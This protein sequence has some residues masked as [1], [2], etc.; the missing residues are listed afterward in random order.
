MVVALVAALAGAIFAPGWAGDGAAR[1]SAARPQASPRKAYAL[2]PGSGWV[3][4]ELLVRFRDGVSRQVAREVHG[5]TGARLA[6]HIAGLGIDLVR[7]PTGVSIE[8]ALEVY[9]ADPRV[10]IVEPNLIRAPSDL[11]PND[12]DFGELWALLNTGQDHKLADSRFLRAAGT[13]DADIDATEAWDLETGD[14]AVVVGVIDTGVDVNHPDLAGSLWVNP[15]EVAGNGLDD[16]GNGYVDDVNGWNFADGN[17]DL[18]DEIGHGTHVAGII[19]AQLDNGIGTA[20]VCPGCRIMVLKFDLDL[21]SELEAL[22]YAAANGAVVV[23]GSYSGGQWSRL[24]RD[25]FRRAGQAGVLSV[26][27]AGNQSSDNDMAL[28]VDADGVGDSPAF[29]ASYD[30]SSIVSVAASNHRDENGYS[31]ACDM[32][33][34]PRYPCA[35]TNW[36]HDSV[37]LSAPGVDILST[38]PGGFGVFSGTSMAAP[39][40]AGVAG[41]VKSLHPSYTPE[42]VK[43]AMLGSVDHP[44]SLGVLEAFPGGPDNGQFTRTGGRLNAHQAL[45]V[46]AGAGPPQGDGNVQ[47]AKTIKMAAGGYVRWPQDVNDVYRKV[48]TRGRTYRVTV[49]GP[50][51]KDYDLL[52]WKPGTTEIWQFEA[53]CLGFGSCALRAQSAGATADETVTFN[54]KRGGTY[55]FQVT[56][57]FSQGRYTLTV[58]R[59]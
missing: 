16:D 4:G 33:P 19:A 23:N 50:P 44:A 46:S 12:M 42:Q 38:V 34:G 13:V 28:D 5:L 49:D 17:A 35:F 39:H 47:G 45:L 22:A 30:L 58:K 36:G 2:P 41:L 20:G 14:P 18:T 51:G 25:A 48:L 21:A 53:G 37:D 9:A 56:S 24:E 40:V 57:F 26:L 55:Y 10:A 59:I 43:Q 31:T 54:A 11:V 52:V 8:R 32:A 1:A 3:G 27:S 7:L 6:G 29:P 15:G